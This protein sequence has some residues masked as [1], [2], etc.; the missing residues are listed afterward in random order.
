MLEVRSFE[1]CKPSTRL[2]SPSITNATNCKQCLLN[3]KRGSST[4]SSSTSR[5]TVTQLRQHRCHYYCCLSLAQSAVQSRAAR[6]HDRCPVDSSISYQ[7][8]SSIHTHM[9]RSHIGIRSVVNT[10]TSVNAS[11]CY[12]QWTNNNL[13]AQ[14]VYSIFNFTITPLLTRC[15]INI[16]YWLLTLKAVKLVAFSWLI[17]QLTAS[18][19]HKCILSLTVAG[20]PLDIA[21]NVITF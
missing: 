13:C 15:S 12:M 2:V 6:Q 9:P 16:D 4:V 7:A 20:W 3:E 18:N 14:H 19:R 1:H 10:T 17:Y 8:A 21:D 11:Q 5:P